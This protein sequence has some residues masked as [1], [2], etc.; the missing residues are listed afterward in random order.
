MYRCVGCGDFKMTEGVVKAPVLVKITL[1]KIVFL[2]NFSREV[3]PLLQ[4]V[5][6][7][8][9]FTQINI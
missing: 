2:N 5:I 6:N 7:N 3:M 4:N 9:K 1:F 8:E